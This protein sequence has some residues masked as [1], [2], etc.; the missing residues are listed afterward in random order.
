MDDA[1]AALG[2]RWTMIS[3]Y[4]FA[5][6]TRELRCRIACAIAAGTPRNGVKSGDL[7]TQGGA[8]AATRR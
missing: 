5:R 8:N 2:K 6:T 4:R 7:T 1:N 3:E